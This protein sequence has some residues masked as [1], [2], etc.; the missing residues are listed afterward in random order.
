PSSDAITGRILDA[1]GRPASFAVVRI[2]AAGERARRAGMGDSC[3]VTARA[4]ADGRFRIAGFGARRVRVVAEND[5][6]GF[7]ESEEL[8]RPAAHPV[9]LVLERAARVEGVV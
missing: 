5:E 2:V 6:D 7:V 1:E 4:D 9:V 3:A 8:D